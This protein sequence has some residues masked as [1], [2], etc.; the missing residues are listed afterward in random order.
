MVAVF[1]ATAIGIVTPTAA[2]VRRLAHNDKPRV[3]IKF[4]RDCVFIAAARKTRQNACAEAFATF[5]EWPT[6]RCPR[7]TPDK[8]CEDVARAERK[9]ADVTERFG[10]REFECEGN[11]H[12]WA[13]RTGNIGLFPPIVFLPLAP[14]KFLVELDC[15]GGAYNTNDIYLFYD[16]TVTPPMLK[17][18]RFPWYRLHGDPNWTST[19]KTVPRMTWIEAVSGRSFNRRRHELTALVKYRGVGDCGEFA[20]FGFRDGMPALR[21]FRFK[22]ECD[23][24]FVYS[25]YSQG[26][27]N[28]SP[29]SPKGWWDLPVE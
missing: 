15:I 21:E 6:A 11:D 26:V 19:E 22:L 23:N 9:M 14:G 29:P 10:S 25:H 12:A 3:A 4:A 18:L 17:R 8:T 5:T 7:E 28:H 13:V 24:R 20:R 2:Q 27:T 16:E 1:L